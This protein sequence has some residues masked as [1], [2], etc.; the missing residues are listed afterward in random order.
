MASHMPDDNDSGLKDDPALVSSSNNNADG[1]FTDSQGYGLE[2][3]PI[4]TSNDDTSEILAES[5]DGLEDESLFTNDNA[6]GIFANSHDFTVV[7]GTFI[8][9]TNNYGTT[10]TVPPG[11][12]MI[13]N[14]GDIV[15]QRELTSNEG[16]PVVSC[17]DRK[18]MRRVYSAKVGQR[19]DL[20]VAMYEG[21]SAEEE[22]REDIERYM[23]IRHP[24]IMQIWAG[25][26][27]PNLHAMVF[28]GDLVPIKV[29][30]AGRSPI[31]TV[32]LYTLYTCE[33]Q[34]AKT[35]L[36]SA[37]S[38]TPVGS[39]Q[40]TLW[41]RSSTGQL[42]ADIRP[43]D[44][45]NEVSL[46]FN[47]PPA[48]PGFTSQEATAIGFLSLEQYH[49]ICDLYLGKPRGEYISTAATVT[50]GMVSFWPAHLDWHDSVGIVFL[51]AVNLQQHDISWPFWEGDPL[52]RGDMMESG[53]TRSESGHFSESLS[54]VIT[55]VAPG[56]F[57]PPM[58]W[59]SQANH[60]FSRLGITS[61]LGDYV[62]VYAVQFKITLSHPWPPCTTGYLFLCPPAD[63]QIGATS[64]RGPEKSPAYWS[65]D[66]AGVQ[67]YRWP[68]SPAYWS[69]DP[70]GAH[71]LT[72]EEATGLGF[73]VLQLSTHIV[74]RSWDTSVY[75]GLRKFHEAKGFNPDSQDVARHLGEPLFKS[76][77][78]V[79]LIT[80][81]ESII[82]LLGYLFRLILSS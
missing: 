65:I 71:R 69:L 45:H 17:R 7:G 38:R 80:D 51:P 28:H 50:L 5:L 9:T 43:P 46:F 6:G 73:P 22:W 44:Q 53:W 78:R 52:Y 79:L 12:H 42:S 40:H 18:C 41:I 35:Y 49:H 30:M 66:P 67:S 26:S 63:F 16:S 2:D 56:L 15:L 10:P 13:P 31:M 34:R 61:N 54:S 55:F 29:F 14:L 11:L 25:A 39:K 60:I 32:Y 24:N 20:T 59:L 33:W 37:F 68:E 58:A 48:L 21:E 36:A 27:Y 19:S 62:L 77:P 23:S 81:G 8:N 3:D 57:H 75:T 74:G 1:I 70:A 72:I 47:I 82:N 4:S 76:T 64:Y